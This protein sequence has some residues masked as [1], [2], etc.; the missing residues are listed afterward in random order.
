MDANDVAQDEYAVP[1]PHA[2]IS[3]IKAR[4]NKTT[5]KWLTCSIFASFDEENI[6]VLISEKMAK[7]AEGLYEDIFQKYLRH[8]NTR[9]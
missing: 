2:L 7:I 6:A 1:N 9:H 8:K 4:E 3:F 5:T